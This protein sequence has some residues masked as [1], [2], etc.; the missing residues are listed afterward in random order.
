MTKH[1]EEK[2]DEHLLQLMENLQLFEDSDHTSMKNL[3]PQEIHMISLVGR[4]DFP[5]MSDIARRG[6][7]TRGA[8]SI[9]IGKL[10]NKGYVKRVGDDEDRRVV[11]VKL[12]ARGETVDR[13]HRKYHKRINAR[14]MKPLTKSEKR[15]LEKLMRKMV[16]TLG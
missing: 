12:T 1:I 3:T 8:V 15:G 5:R 6:H 7:V 10:E 11:H 16:A 13:D 2:I 4:L 14:I 9:M